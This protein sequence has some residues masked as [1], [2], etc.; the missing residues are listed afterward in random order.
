[1]AATLFS[2][3]LEAYRTNDSQMKKAEWLKMLPYMERAMHES[4]RRA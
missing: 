3:L 1:M 4:R 2:V